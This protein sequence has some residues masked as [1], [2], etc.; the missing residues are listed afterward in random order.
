MPERQLTTAPHGHVLTNANVWSPDGRRV[1][2]DVRSDPAGSAFDGTRIESVDVGTGVVR[3]L[4]ESRDGA[5]CGVVTHSPADDRVVF[6]LGPERPTP[7]FDYGPDRR[8]GVV[9]DARRPGVAT[10]LD[11]RDLV[12]PFTPG[13][14]RGGS[15]VHLFDAGGEWVSFTYNDFVLGALD[16]AKAPLTGRETD[17]RN[18]GVSVPVAAGVRVGRGHP[19]NHDGS[20]FSVLATRTVN[21]PVPGSDQIRRALE[22]AWV[23]TRGYLRPDGTRQR[24]AIAFQGEVLA[25]DGSPVSEVFVVDLPDD[26]T[27]PSPD[28]PLHGTPTRRPL[29][30]RGTVQRRLTRTTGRSH[31]G[32]Q[33]PRHWLRSSPDGSRVAFLMRDDAGVVQLFTVSPNGGEPAQVTRN[34]WH[35]ASAFTWSPDGRAVAHVMDNSVFVTDVATGRGTRL[36]PRADDPDAPRPEACVLSPDGKRVAYVRNV[37]TAGRRWNQVFAVDV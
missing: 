18:V 14:L 20:A 17:Q 9:V 12:P 21:D 2:Y 7:D 15:H 19:R 22:D 33:G 4:Y 35:V 23:G 3:V 10:P 6:I 32:V 29:P 26:V 13:A 1:V 30:P 16:R 28:G 31:P 36:T 8:Q 5:C 24:R 27:A 11:A 25:A 34:P 37:V